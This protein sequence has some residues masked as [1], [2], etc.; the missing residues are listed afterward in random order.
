MRRKRFNV[1]MT[2]GATVL[3]VIEI[4]LAAIVALIVG[5][6]LF[7]SVFRTFDKGMNRY[8]IESTVT[9]KDVKNSGDDSKYLVFTKDDSG[10][11]HVFEITDSWIAGRFNSSDTYAEIEVGKKY[12]FT[13][14]GKRVP[15]LSWYPNIYEFE[16]LNDE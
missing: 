13:V 15:L 3:V 11:V 6:T 5:F 12:R 16:E 4:A 8:D 9:D 7:G 14:G 10:E 2:R 1:S